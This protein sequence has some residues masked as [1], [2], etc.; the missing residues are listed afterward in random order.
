MKL[1]SR[2]GNYPKTKIFLTA[3]VALIA[4]R[5]LL[6][7]IGLRAINWALGNKMGVYHGWIEDF[8]L[9]LHRGAYQLQGLVI[10]KRDKSSPPIVQIKEID[11]SLSW[12]ALL[13]KEVAANVTADELKIQLIDDKNRDKQQLGRE[14]SGKDWSAVGGVLVPVAIENLEIKNSSIAFTN[15]SLK[16]P[17][18]VEMTDIHLTAKNLRTR[19]ATEQ[20]ALSA[21]NLEAIIQKHAKLTVGGNIDLMSDPQ[22]ADLDMSLIGL[23]I[24]SLNGILLSYLPLDIT[25][26]RLSA[27]GEVA[28][29]QGRGKA[30]VKLFLKDADIVARH[31][32]FISLKHLGFELLGAFGNWLLKNPETKNLAF[33]LPIDWNGKEV[34]IGASEAF[35]SAVDNQDDPMKRGVE[36]SLTLKNVAVGE[37]K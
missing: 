1:T 23:D 10:E 26:G 14:D 20:E 16:K 33:H 15:T 21:F 25:S 37:K 2:L 36:N 13:R 8:D 32:N 4:L 28:T 9:N 18:P 19:P 6:P 30:Y 5:A 12:P 22:R 29:T 27:Y 7:I 3:I 35:W 34:D 31:Q 17:L 11:L 24:K